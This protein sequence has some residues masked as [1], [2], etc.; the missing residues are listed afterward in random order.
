[1]WDGV[2]RGDGVQRVD[3]EPNCGGFILSHVECN[4]D[5][6][7]GGRE[8]KAAAGGGGREGEEE[9]DAVAMGKRVEVVD[10][11]GEGGGE[12]GVGV[13]DWVEEGNGVVVEECP[14][15]DGGGKVDECEVY[16]AVFEVG[17]PH[18]C[19]IAR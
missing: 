4:C 2:N 13:G 19:D 8:A 11:E 14:G 3:V 1:M 5:K 6:G 9:G 12:G 17:I 15:A 10:D 7:G 16:A 18:Q